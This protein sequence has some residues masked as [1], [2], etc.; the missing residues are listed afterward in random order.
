MH[1]QFINGYR[2]EEGNFMMKTPSTDKFSRRLVCCMVNYKYLG[3]QK[4]H[5]DAAILFS[6]HCF[7]MN[8]AASV[9]L[10]GHL[11]YRWNTT[12]TSSRNIAESMEAFWWLQGRK[13]GHSITVQSY[14]KYTPP[15]GTHWRCHSV[16][17][18]NRTVLVMCMSSTLT[19]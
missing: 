8:N 17:I 19:V 15:D 13:E 6:S 2:K 3:V 7:A 4:H 16:L 9:A 11:S 1:S 12:E 14:H 5:S 10:F 18:H